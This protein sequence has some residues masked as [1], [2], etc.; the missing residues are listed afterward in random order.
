MYYSIIQL[1]K[2]ALALGTTINQIFELELTDLYQ[3]F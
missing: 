1:A 2:A 3:S